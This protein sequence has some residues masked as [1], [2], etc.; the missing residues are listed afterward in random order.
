[1]SSTIENNAIFKRLRERKNLFETIQTGIFI[2]L[3]NNPNRIIFI[4]S[5]LQNHP[6]VI[7][8]EVHD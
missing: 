1:M 8:V 7:S 4:Y 3:N 5:K 2:V 6:P